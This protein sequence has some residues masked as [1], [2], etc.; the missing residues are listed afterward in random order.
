MTKTR[1]HFE[2]PHSAMYILL[3]AP[4]SSRSSRGMSVVGGKYIDISIFGRAWVG[5]PKMSFVSAS[6]LRSGARTGI[7]AR[8]MHFRTYFS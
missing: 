6:M 8:L 3:E 1:R 5:V 2:G 4:S 7:R